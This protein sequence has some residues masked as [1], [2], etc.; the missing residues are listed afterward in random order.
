MHRRSRIGAVALA[1][2]VLAGG[3]AVASASQRAEPLALACIS[4]GGTFTCPM[5]APVT[6]TDLSTVVEPAVTITEPGTTVTSTASGPTVTSTVTATPT[7]SAPA[8]TVAPTTT[9]QPAPG[10]PS[11]EAMPVGN[12]P[13]WTQVQTDDF[14]APLSSAKWFTP[15]YSG[16]IPSAPGAYW[17]GSQVKVRDGKLVLETAKIGERWTSGGVMN[18]TNLTY[19]KILIRTRID[20]SPGVKYA[21]LLWPQT[22]NTWYTGGEI[23]FAEDGGGA[24]TGTTGTVIWFAGG[25]P[26]GKQQIQ[27]STIADFSQWHTLGVEWSPGKLVYTLDGKAFGTVD[28]VNVPSGPMKMAL[29]TEALITC[30]QWNTCVGP[31]TPPLTSAEFDWVAIYARS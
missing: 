15:G 8:T 27:R 17:A 23:D 20:K 10:S 22:P 12:L 19:G 11:G 1:V 25:V 4:D 24:R 6:V 16:E 5:P 26:Q 7:S 3:S 28:S 30:S 21:H 9:T 29:Q 13:G 18:R 31:T 2:V 14:T